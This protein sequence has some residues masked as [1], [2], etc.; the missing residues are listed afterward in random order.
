MGK[1]QFFFFSSINLSKSSYTF[2]KVLN[3][4]RTVATTTTTTT[5]TTTTT[6]T[7]AT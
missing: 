7:K 2:P 5:A 6:T 1:S 4:T 3:Q